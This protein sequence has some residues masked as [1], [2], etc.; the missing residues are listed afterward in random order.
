MNGNQW[1]PWTVVK[2]KNETKP[3]DWWE[4]ISFGQRVGYVSQ[5]LLQGMDQKTSWKQKIDERSVHCTDSLIQV[6]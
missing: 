1:L 5:K 3:E 2:N 4:L 6:L